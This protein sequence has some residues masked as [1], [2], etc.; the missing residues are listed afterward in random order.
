MIRHL[1]TLF[2]CLLISVG[3]VFSQDSSTT[4]DDVIKKRALERPSSWRGDSLFEKVDSKA[5]AVS[6]RYEFDPEHPMRRLYAYGWAVGNVAIGD[7]NGDGKA[8]LFFP[9]TTGEHRV[10]LQ[11]DEFRFGEVTSRVNAGGKEGW[12]S[13]A[14]MAD[15]DNDRD[16][17][18]LVI[19]YDSPNQLLINNGDPENLR[20]VDRA[21]EWG[22]DFSDGALTASFC[23]FDLD[24]FLD[25]YIQTYHLEPENGRP[26]KIE[27]RKENEVIRLPEKWE[28][29]YLG[30]ENGEG[31]QRWVE[32]PLSDRF[33][34]NK[35]G[36]FL[37]IGDSGIAVGRSYGTAHLAWD[38]DHDLRP[39][40]Y[41]SND[42]HGPDLNYKLSENGFIETARKVFPYTPWFSRGI[43]SADFNNDLLIDLV[44][45]NSSVPD[46][47]S[48]LRYG[49]P[50]RSDIAR[51]LTSGGA[52][53][54][55]RNILMA[56]NGTSRFRE[57]AN[58]AGIGNTGATWAVK[59][60]DYDC[61]GL[62]DLFF[63][64]GQARQ[65]SALPSAALIGES[66]SGKTR[67]DILQKHPE[68]RQT[69]RAFQNLGNWKFGDTSKD[70]G[71][72]HAG[73]SYS[74]G[75]GDL[76]GDGDLDL[77]VCPLGENVIL[78]RNHSSQNRVVISLDGE[79]T[80]EFGHGAE[81]LCAIENAPG[82]LMQM[83]PTGGFKG[84]DEAAFFIGMG[85]TETLNRVSIRWPG[86]NAI[87]TLENLEAGYRYEIREVNSLRPPAIRAR[88]GSPMFVGSN[89]L[90]RTG[91]EEIIPNLPDAQP[92]LP[93]AIDR[94][95][96][97]VAA[98]DLDGDGNLEIYLGG[99]EAH[100][101]HFVAGNVELA[102]ANHPFRSYAAWEDAAAVFFDANGDGREDL[103]VASS[104]FQ[105]GTDPKLMMDRLYFL[106]PNG[107]YIDA[108]KSHLPNATV[109]S[110]AVAV[111]DFDKDG[112]LDLFVGAHH[113]VGKYPSPDRSRIL[114]NNGSGKFADST[115]A[116]AAGLENAGIVNSAIWSDVDNDG[117]LDLLLVCEW[118]TP[119]LWKNQDG[120]LTNQSKE[121]GLDQLTGKW[122]SITG[123]DIDG[124]G[125]IDYVVTNEGENGVLQASQDQPAQLFAGD[126]AGNG[127]QIPITLVGG[128]PIHGWEELAFAGFP[129]SK[130]GKSPQEFVASFLT[131]NFSAARLSESA[132]ASASATEL[133]SGLLM[134]EGSGA[135][136]FKALPAEAQCSEGMGCIVSDF[137]FDGRADLFLVQNRGGGSLAHP[138]ALN[139]GISQLFLGT[140]NAENPLWPV[141]A[142]NSG[143][144]IY[145][146][147]RGATAVDLNRD[148]KPDIL[149]TI[150]GSDPAIFA[151]NIKVGRTQPLPIPL[152][153]ADGKQAAGARV[154]V[155]IIGFPTQTAEYYAGGGYYSQSP[156]TLFFGA[157]A[158]GSRVA[159]VS[160]RWSDGTKSSRTI[161]ITDESSPQGESPSPQ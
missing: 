58:F 51:A 156:R 8:D 146:F 3:Q 104:S 50:F 25:L 97:S 69:D 117:W 36:K 112:D 148:N 60:G 114:L 149:A 21:K 77:V 160:I 132:S 16:L 119:Q 53:Q 161:P 108:S 26:D 73:M 116:L 125:D 143:L 57:M 19:N 99:S 22:L 144:V 76:D 86:S 82:R 109:N 84:S 158:G 59:A 27:T 95:G 126:F 47:L 65:W 153:G 33:F 78:Y 79:K 49:E 140:G 85:E 138:E 54:R 17:D 155:E 55:N 128:L 93:P 133:R 92:L 72:D 45:A 71:L 139:A 159:K 56:N 98:I 13:A 46:P 61:D 70:W 41:V 118:G 110:S 89:A 67:W 129:E 11:R 80:N 83:H 6:M 15:V 75:Q 141:Q 29:S 18:V 44:V 1:L 40:L 43:A 88:R 134:N 106:Q 107:D 32:A 90:K 74:V 127:K 23:D 35:N 48:Q 100:N 130:I 101:P 52:I 2:F 39:D 145:G 142:E 4:D 151:N 111:A 96:P 9:G 10:F 91:E 103:Y 42:S 154:T 12:G 150:N 24:G 123:G 115:S 62:V 34:T 64:T 87:T 124:D 135:L 121:W 131:K 81:I 136:R 152:F 14:V 63:A 120:R 157:P 147:G 137:N 66:L 94:A 122:N 20:F 37:P 68:D 38:P 7:L 105:S 5:T 113:L 31:K 102:K 28:Q 30:Y